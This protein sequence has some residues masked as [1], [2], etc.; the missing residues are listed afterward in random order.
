MTQTEKSWV[1][2]VD[3]DPLVLKALGRLLQTEGYNVCVFDSP[4]AFLDAHDP[5][6]PGCTLLDVGMTELSGLETQNE[7]LA[8]G[9][10]R[11]IIF[12]TGQDDVRTGILAMKAGARDYLIKPVPP[13]VLLE[14]VAAAVQGDL[15][16][17]RERARLAEIVRRWETLTKREQEVMVQVALGR[18]NKQIAFDLGIVEKTTKVHRARI[19]EKMAVRSVAA[20]VHA[21]EQL[22]RAGYLSKAG[23]P[24]VRIQ[25]NARSA[26]GTQHP[27]RPVS[28]EQ[29]DTVHD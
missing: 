21:V 13:A 24:G 25:S 5:S 26:H 1:Y 4:R 12:I 17:S 3:D 14:A 6:L 20:L 19:M 22:E 23:S 15:A 28:S 18:L 10:T 29:D 16:A 11:P 27:R 8:L 7:L 9:D 2:V